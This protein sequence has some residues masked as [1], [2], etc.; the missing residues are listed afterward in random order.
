MVS[1]IHIAIFLSFEIF[2]TKL[3]DWP[4]VNAYIFWGEEVWSRLKSHATVKWSQVKSNVTKSTAVDLGSIS[5]SSRVM[6]LYRSASQ[7]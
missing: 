7:V 6:F 4:A 1:H 2:Y 5:A 3:E